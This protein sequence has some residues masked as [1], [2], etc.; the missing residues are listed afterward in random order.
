MDVSRRGDRACQNHPLLKSSSSETDVCTI[1]SDEAGLA[2]IL[3]CQAGPSIRKDSQLHSCTS[4]KHLWRGYALPRNSRTTGVAVSNFLC[5]CKAAILAA[6][7]ITTLFNLPANG[8]EPILTI[9]SGSGA[10]DAIVLTREQIQGMPVTTF[11]TSTTWTEGTQ[12]FTGVALVD[13]LRELSTSGS[14]IR[15]TAL[16]DYT[17][18]IPRSDAVEGGP[19]V[20]YFIN[21]KPLSVRDKG[22]LWI[23]YPY[24]SNPNYQTEIVYSRSIWQL[25]R[26]ELID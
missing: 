1:F 21:D 5:S 4:D 15:A 7:C 22:P 25:D 3:F 11:Q 2:R 17:V 12:Q 18:E 14:T 16:N 20:A 19:I 9:T 24:D 6:F 8:A 10:S 26:I 13:L 23:V